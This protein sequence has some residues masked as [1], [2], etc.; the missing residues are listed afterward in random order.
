MDAAAVSM[1]ARFVILVV[2]RAQR[3]VIV[4]GSP[5]RRAISRTWLR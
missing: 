4:L 2:G 1:E 3:H 5:L